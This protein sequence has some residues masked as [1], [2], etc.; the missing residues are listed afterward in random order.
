MTLFYLMSPPFVADLSPLSGAVQFRQGDQAISFQ[1]TASSN[2]IPS[3]NKTYN[4]TLLPPL[5]GRLGNTNTVATVTILA[6]S[7]PYGLFEVFAGVK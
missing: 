2:N 4:V 3:L 6:H 5:E 1:L 7:H